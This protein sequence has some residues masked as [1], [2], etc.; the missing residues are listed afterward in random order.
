MSACDALDHSSTATLI[1]VRMPKGTD[2]LA[3]IAIWA[4][5]AFIWGGI[6]FILAR[7]VGL[8]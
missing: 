1:A 3:A 2:L 5:A 6:V 8:F 4:V 7:A